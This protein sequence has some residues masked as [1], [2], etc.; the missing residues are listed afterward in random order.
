[1]KPSHNVG[2]VLEQCVTNDET[3]EFAKIH[4]LHTAGSIPAVVVKFKLLGEFER[5]LDFLLKTE[6]FGKSK[7]MTTNVFATPV[8]LYLFGAKN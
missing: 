8:L 4:K 5:Y 7:I 1:M 6:L 3:I 2:S